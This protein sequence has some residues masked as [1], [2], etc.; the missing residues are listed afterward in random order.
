M[1]AKAVLDKLWSLILQNNI[2][3]IWCTIKCII[4]YLLNDYLLQDY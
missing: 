4:N 3:T 1:K 2:N